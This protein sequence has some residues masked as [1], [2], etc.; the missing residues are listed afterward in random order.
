MLPEPIPVVKAK[1]TAE[2][3][4][5]IHELAKSFGDNQV[6][7]HFDLV[8]NQGENLVV[9]G[10]SGSGKSVLI[11]CIIR[12][13]EPDSGSIQVLGE[14]IV[15][16][17]EEALD[18]LRVKIGFLFQGNALYDSMTVRQNLEFPLRR[19][20]MNV[21]QGEVD[22][23]VME[24]L[25]NVGLEETLDMMPEELSGGMRKRI[26]LAR[27]LILKPDIILY[28]E[29]TTGLDPITGKEISEL[30]IEVQHKYKTSSLIISHD[31]KCIRRTADRIIVLLDGRCYAEGTY[32][33]L[34]RSSDPQV[35][36]FFE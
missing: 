15:D 18:R 2:P 27:T 13:L 5:A 33:E 16:L 32:A 1:A 24:A 4:I 20:W 31:M 21:S 8:L 7:A 10:K 19:H 17:N 35:K 12:L 30:M 9:L 14:N 26:A 11:K 6:L 25:D 36:N 34:E 22:G 23:L 28:D 29:P 3:V